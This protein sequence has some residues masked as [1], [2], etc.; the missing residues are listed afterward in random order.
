MVTICG[1]TK[2]LKPTFTQCRVLSVLVSDNRLQ[3]D[4]IE[5]A[6]FSKTWSLNLTHS[7]L[8]INSQSS[9]KA[10]KTVKTLKKLFTSATSRGSQITSLSLTG[11]TH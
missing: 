6:T 9:G 4:S 2:I 11:A 10:E 7:Y 3:F 5:L 8:A 1:V